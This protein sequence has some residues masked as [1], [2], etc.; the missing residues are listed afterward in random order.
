LTLKTPL[1]LIAISAL[2]VSATAAFANA[3]VKGSDQ[4]VTVDCRGGPAIVEGASNTVRF[5]GI[6]SSLSITGA[7]NDVSITLASGAKVNIM[8]SSND[9]NWSLNGKIKPA[10]RVQGADNDIVRVQ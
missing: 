4:E 8:G 3:R 7:D 1:H 6:C 9:V 10:V 5:T 2:A